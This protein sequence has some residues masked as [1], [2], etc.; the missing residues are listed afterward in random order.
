M[1]LHKPTLGRSWY[2]YSG[3][4]PRLWRQLHR[5]IA[6]DLGKQIL[7]LNLR[8]SNHVNETPAVGENAVTANS[9]IQG[10]A[11]N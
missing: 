5:H 9:C 11:G 10:L 8:N 3:H 1:K 7:H 4:E 6:N 2:W